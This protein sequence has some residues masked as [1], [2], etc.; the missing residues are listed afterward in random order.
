MAALRLRDP[1]GRRCCVR[2]NRFSCRGVETLNGSSFSFSDFDEGGGGGGS[3]DPAAVSVSR[4]FG[5]DKVNARMGRVVIFSCRVHRRHRA[6]GRAPRSRAMFDAEMRCQCMVEGQGEVQVVVVDQCSLSSADFSRRHSR[7]SN[8]HL[9]VQQTHLPTTTSFQGSITVTHHGVQTSLC[10]CKAPFHQLLRTTTDSHSQHG[11]RSTSSNRHIDII[12]SAILV[13]NTPTST[14][15]LPPTNAMHTLHISNSR[16]DRLRNL[17]INAS[18]PPHTQRH[19]PQSH[20]LRRRQ[21]PLRHSVNE[22]AIRSARLR[23]EDPP[24]E[25]LRKGSIGR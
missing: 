13:N 24:P 18:S 4:H 10:A 2:S 20:H 14:K 5:A 6:S 12:T 1:T 22:M 3:E 19:P 25:R 8:L 7:R 21:R 15:P 11:H 16:T 9:A 17:P 23:A